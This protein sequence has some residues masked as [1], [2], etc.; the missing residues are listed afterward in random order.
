MRTAL[1]FM[2]LVPAI[3]MGLGLA[4]AA[5]TVGNI[6]AS[7]LPDGRISIVYDVAGANAPV[8]VSVVLAGDQIPNV[9]TLTGDVGP[10]VT[11]G[12]DKRIAWDIRRDLPGIYKKNTKINIVASEIGRTMTIKLPG[13]VPLE[14]VRVPAGT[15]LMGSDPTDKLKDESPRHMVRIG[16]DFY[17][18]KCEIT[19]GQWVALMGKNPALIQG[20]G[21]LPVEMI[22]WEAAQEFIEKLNAL[23]QGR[24]RLPTEAEWEYACR[25]GSSAKWS[26]GDDPKQ[27]ENDAW[28]GANSGGTSHVVGT[29]RPNRF[30]LCDM[31]GNVWEWVQDWYHD[32]YAGAPADGGAWSKMDSNLPFKV[33]RGGVFHMSADLARPS[34]RAT[35]YPSQD[36]NWYGLRVVREE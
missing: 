8:M 35:N 25:A 32:G 21:N 22:S 17:L 14:L 12:A 4:H 13:G 34:Y 1:F 10:G 3:A 11:G 29:R 31:E 20:D 33:V 19:Q 5:P 18:G 24:F 16:R 30:G 27:L 26:C 15:F 7:A 36:D 23:G 28:F 6:R 2:Q 9:A